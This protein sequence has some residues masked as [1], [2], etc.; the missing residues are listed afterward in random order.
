MSLIQ[1]TLEI[2]ADSARQA[3]DGLKRTGWAIVFLMLTNLVTAMIA[4]AIGGSAMGAGIVI[5]LLVFV[6]ECWLLGA[7]LSMLEVGVS[8]H[9]TL[10]LDD[11]RDHLGQYFNKAMSVR[12]LFWIPLFLFSWIRPELS[13]IWLLVS[14]LICNPIPEM[15]YQENAER[16]VDLAIEAA[17]FMQR[18]WPEWLIAQL[19]AFS[20]VLALQVALGGSLGLEGALGLL[21]MFGPNFGFIGVHAVAA[22]LASGSVVVTAFFALLFTYGHV[23]LLFRGCLY[24]RLRVSSRRQREWKSK[25]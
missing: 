8:G 25:F 17:N 23:V 15:V 20:P 6:L 5:G 11:M 16:G 2:Y 7:Y 19:L 24:K 4:T 22:S 21:Q 1:Q 3:W 13:L 10:S 18:N 12:F 14:A 9:G